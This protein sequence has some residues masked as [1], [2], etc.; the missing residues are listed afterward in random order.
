M[1]REPQVSLVRPPVGS[2]ARDSSLA[3]RR[4]DADF[5]GVCRRED[6]DAVE[7]VCFDV[8]LARASEDLR[9][10]GGFDGMRDVGAARALAAEARCG[11]ELLGVR[12][13]VRIEGVAH[14]VH[15]GEVGFGEHV[16]HDA[17]LLSADAVLAG[18]GAA[19]VDA[20]L[21]DLVG[22]IECAL[23][24]AF[25]GAVVE[26]HGMKVAV[27]GV[28]DVG[29]AQAGL[30]G[31]RLHLVE[32]ARERGARDD[33]VLHDVVGRDAAHGGEG[34]FAALPDESAFGV[35][36]RESLFPCAVLCAEL[37]D[38]LHLRVDFVDG[39]VELDE[40]K[41][42]AVGVA[43][44]DRGFGGEDGGAVHHLHRGGKHAGGDDVG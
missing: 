37:A 24:F 18:D 16:A 5:V 12:D 40:Q 41:T 27:A 9:E 31:H 44:V 42:F 13:V 11:E 39:A 7:L 15:G 35:G 19:G 30:G 1:T 17:L 21:E 32:D 8:E 28:E 22:E 36:L 20:E 23:L 43:G 14:A 3:A 4:M 2:T 10:A 25:V 29:D 6:G 33:A 38:A 26:N 34:G